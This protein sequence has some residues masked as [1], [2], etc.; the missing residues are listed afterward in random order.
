MEAQRAA[1]VA[2]VADVRTWQAQDHAPEPPGVLALVRVG[3]VVAVVSVWP[4]LRQ[5]H[6]MTS[7]PEITREADLIASMPFT[8][9]SGSRDGGCRARSREE[10]A[11]GLG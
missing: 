4:A 11:P 9:V 5:S 6:I 8:M 1:T 10:N 2:N 7:R 3:T